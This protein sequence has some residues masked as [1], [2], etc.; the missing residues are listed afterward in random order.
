[1]P[2]TWHG[3]AARGLARGPVPVAEANSEQE[4]YAVPRRP[5]LVP[6]E[7]K[8]AYPNKFYGDKADTDNFIFEMK[9]YLDTIEI[10]SGER[11]CRVIVSY[12]KKDALDWWRDYQRTHTS[13]LHEMDADMLLDELKAAFCDL[14]EV[15]KLRD[16]LWNL[17][18]TTT[19]AD[20]AL[21]LK[22]IQLKLG[23]NRL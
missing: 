2:G 4:S 11:A 5:T 15:S 14:D 7:I 23:E 19:V 9:Q 16:K 10:G 20:F 13:L 8:I 6:K 12:L 22:R 18:Q 1:M 17:K 3:V 21:N